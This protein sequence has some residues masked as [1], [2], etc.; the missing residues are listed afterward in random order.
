MTYILPL[1]YKDAFDDF[2]Q[3]QMREEQLAQS[4][5]ITIR[6]HS[7]RIM[8]K[9]DRVASSTTETIELSH[10]Q[11]FVALKELEYAINNIDELKNREILIDLHDEMISFLNKR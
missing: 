9:L 3:T 1:Q 2:W 8:E 7:K 6:A 4:S 5:D 10:D 11:V